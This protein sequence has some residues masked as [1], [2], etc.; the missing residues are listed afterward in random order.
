MD[1]FMEMESTSKTAASILSSSQ[2]RGKTT[3]AWTHD[4]NKKLSNNFHMIL[5][6]IKIQFYM[7]FE[8]KTW[9]KDGTLHASRGEYIDKNDTLLHL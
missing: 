4:N 8:S 7:F 3:T 9:I 1:K 5:V 2:D 6:M